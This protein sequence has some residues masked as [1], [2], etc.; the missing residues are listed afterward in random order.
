M[1]RTIE[2]SVNNRQTAIVLPVNPKSIQIPGVQKNQTIDLLNTGE[3]LVLGNRGLNSLSF[4]SF[5][6]ATDS[7]FFRYA[8]RAPWEYFN[9]LDSW[10]T[11]KT[12]VRLI[13]GG[14]SINMAAAIEKLT[15][16]IHEGDADLYY[17]IDLSEYRRLNVPALQHSTVQQVNGL[18]ERPDTKQKPVAHIVR[19]LDETL[20]KTIANA[21]GKELAYDVQLGDRIVL[22]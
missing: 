12:V 7:P 20:W 21:N 5:F 9:L 17:T 18:N 3:V 16:E 4:S 11:G 14:S 1:Q 22:P 19:S 2:L 8:E 13:I 6:P 10:R 15:P